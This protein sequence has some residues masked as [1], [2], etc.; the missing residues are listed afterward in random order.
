VDLALFLLG[1][2]ALSQGELSEWAARFGF[3]RRPEDP[4]R[5]MRV[6]P[7]PGPVAFGS[8]IVAGVRGAV[9]PVAVVAAGL[10]LDCMRAVGCARETPR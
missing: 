6:V 3:D 2:T 4:G 7:A 8:H 9:S 5:L 10:T 1:E